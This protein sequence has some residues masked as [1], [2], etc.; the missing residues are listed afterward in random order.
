MSR[1]QES[2]SPLLEAARIYVNQF[3]FSIIPIRPDKRPWIKWESYQKRKATP[4]EIQKWWTQWPSA[5]GGIVTGSISGCVVVDIDTNEGW[6]GIQGGLP[7]SLLV[8]TARTPRGGRH[9]Y[10][11]APERPISNATSISLRCGADRGNGKGKKRP[12]TQ[13]GSSMRIEILQIRFLPPGRS[14]RAFVDIKVGEWVIQDF[15]VI[16][17]DSGKTLVSAPQVSWKDPA[18]GEIKYKTVLTIPSEQKQE[19]DIAILKRFTEEL[20]KKDGKQKK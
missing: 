4:E 19:I 9:L 11:K 13:K 12:A 7:D 18:T 1:W 15:R 3:G 5:M 17:H 2:R 16:K 20:E 14:L 6:E 10:F 8:P